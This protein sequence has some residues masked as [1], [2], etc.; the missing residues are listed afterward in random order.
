MRTAD[1]GGGR[2][3]AR[4]ALTELCPRP[5]RTHRS[6][7]ASAPRAIGNYDALTANHSVLRSVATP[8]LP[9]GEGAL[10]EV[11]ASSG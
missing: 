4:A 3:F 11:S 1:G 6:P 9:L 8:G 7:P 5:R 2:L 10:T